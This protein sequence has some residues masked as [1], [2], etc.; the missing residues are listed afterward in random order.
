MFAWMAAGE[1]VALKD[2]ALEQDAKLPATIDHGDTLRLH[3]IFVLK[4]LDGQS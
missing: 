3:C 1:N 2:S 4:F